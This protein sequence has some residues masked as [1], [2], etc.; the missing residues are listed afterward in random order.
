MVKL[1]ILVSTDTPS[2][3]KGTASV[4]HPI[5]TGKLF[6]GTGGQAVPSFI[7]EEVMGDS[8]TFT[9]NLYK[10]FS[11]SYTLELAPNHLYSFPEEEVALS[12]KFR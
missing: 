3:Y 10:P 5:I 7:L 11:A 6:K 1:T 12:F 4:R 9:V 2:V 8:Y